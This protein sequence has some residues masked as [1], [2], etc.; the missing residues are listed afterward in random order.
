MT[1]A[2]IPDYEGLYEVSDEG[3]VRSVDRTIIRKGD[4]EVNLKGRLLRP[5]KDKFGYLMVTLSSGGVTLSKSVHAL[6]A[7]AFLGERPKNYDVRHLNDN[8]TDNRAVNLEYRPRS[9][10]VAN[11]WITRRRTH[12]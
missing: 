11:Q 6:V 2:S 1:W 7:E 5:G 8:I 3:E 10:T 4:V 9:E 12:E